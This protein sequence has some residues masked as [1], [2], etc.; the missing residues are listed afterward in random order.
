[1]GDEERERLRA[2]LGRVRGSPWS[3]VGL[4]LFLPDDEDEGLVDLSVYASV[5]ASVNVPFNTGNNRRTSGRCAGR[6]AD[7]RTATG[8]TTG[9]RVR[10][11][12]IGLRESFRRGTAFVVSLIGKC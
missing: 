5:Y 6:R 7:R 2:G 9:G 12:D 8:W 10:F 3:W 4:S 11:C 1:M